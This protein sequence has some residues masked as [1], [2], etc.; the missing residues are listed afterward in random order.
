MNI[1]RVEDLP[2][3]K[4][5]VCRMAGKV[6]NTNIQYVCI[7]EGLVPSTAQ[8]SVS[9][10]TI[11]VSID[12]NKLRNKEERSMTEKPVQH[13]LGIGGRCPACKEMKEGLQQIKSQDPEYPVELE[14]PECGSRFGKAKA[15]LLFV[16]IPRYEDQ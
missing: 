3:W 7:H 9:H 13:M 8:A 16:A 14:C 4:R 2:W 6:L 12:M 15:D 1:I 5:K 11:T 10:H